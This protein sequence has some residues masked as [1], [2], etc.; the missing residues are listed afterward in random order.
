[1]SMQGEELARDETVALIGSDKVAGTS[2]YG[3]D[4]GRIG[5]I[6]RL[7]IEKRSGQVSYAVLSFGGLLGM[8]AKRHPLPWTS[9]TYDVGLDGYLVALTRDELEAAP[10]FGADEEPDWNDRSWDRGVRDH[11]GAGW[12]VPPV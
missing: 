1:M 12:P 8:G 9:L 7:M 4:G 3:A 11:Y 2:V 10:S 6:E 5:S